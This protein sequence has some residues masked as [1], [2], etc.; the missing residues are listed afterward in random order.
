MIDKYCDEEV[1]GAE[2]EKNKMDCGSTVHCTLLQRMRKRTRSGKTHLW[3]YLHD[4][5]QP[6][7]RCPER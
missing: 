4:K 6:L 1:N 3:G 7:F 5:K 2:N